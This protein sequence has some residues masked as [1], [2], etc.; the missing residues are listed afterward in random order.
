MASSGAAA[1]FTGLSRKAL[2]SGEIMVQFAWRKFPAWPSLP[3]G[4]SRCSFS[5]LCTCPKPMIPKHFGWIHRLGKGA[6][7]GVLREIDVSGQTRK[8]LLV[9]AFGELQPRLPRWIY[10]AFSMSPCHQ[11]CELL[12]Q[13]LHA[14]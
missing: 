9:Q 10:I 7:P 14:H 2:S 4:S 8:A 1:L 13:F 6:N 12:D 11:L 3:T 5:K